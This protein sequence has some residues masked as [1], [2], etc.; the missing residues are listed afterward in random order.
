MSLAAQGQLAGETEKGTLAE[1]RRTRNREQPENENPGASQR[2]PV[3][4]QSRG[5]W[6]R[7]LHPWGPVCAPEVM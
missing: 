6:A 5:C 4:A 7:S 2:V 3:V 1:R